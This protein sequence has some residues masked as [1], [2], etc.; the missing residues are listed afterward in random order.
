M[1]Y[2]DRLV[3]IQKTNYLN[4]H[5]SKSKVSRNYHKT[6]KSGKEKSSK[7][8]QNDNFNLIGKPIKKEKKKK[9]KKFKCKWN[10]KFSRYHNASKNALYDYQIDGYKQ[11]L[12]DDALKQINYILKLMETCNNKDFI[13]CKIKE[14]NNF[15]D[16]YDIVDELV[17]NKRQM[18]FDSFE[19]KFK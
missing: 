12:T 4:I 8:I 18:I 3:D 14:I 15:I 17:L 9:K 11:G 13:N 5:R 10:F 2:E 7:A 1:D 19:N 16:H 6:H